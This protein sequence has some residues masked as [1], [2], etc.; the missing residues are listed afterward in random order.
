MKLVFI[1]GPP[2]VGKLGV[3]RKLS[4]LT[5]Y[6]LFH[7]HLTLDLIDSI[8]DCNNPIYWKLVDKIRLDI[9]EKTNQS[10]IN[11]IIFTY[12]SVVSNNFAFLKKVIKRVDGNNG[13]V[14]LVHLI[15]ST[16]ELYKRVR[17]RSRSFFSKTTTI[18]NLR[19]ILKTWDFYTKFPNHKT[20][21]ID[22]TH[23]SA[24]R[25]SRIIAKHYRLP[26]LEKK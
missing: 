22:N 3:A 25:C 11:G 10:D 1:H 19:K 14:Y 2:S 8:F 16:K 12:G 24:N 9:F 20:L 17:L 21:I 18:K 4:R 15:C 23:I 5:G 13:K 26:T 6:K 7:N